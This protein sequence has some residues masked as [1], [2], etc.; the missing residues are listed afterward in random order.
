MQ[1]ANAFDSVLREKL[2]RRLFLNTTQDQRILYWDLRLASRQTFNSWDGQLMG[3][4]HDQR[5][6][7]YW[8]PNSSDHYKIYNKELL[9][10]AQDSGIGSSV[11]GG[12]LHKESLA[13]FGCFRGLK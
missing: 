12:D 13:H 4:I 3:P 9:R 1:A 8:G 6:V 5:R 11:G 10:E 7:E 2:V